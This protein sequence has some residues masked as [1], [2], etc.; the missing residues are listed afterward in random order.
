MLHYLM[1]K[2][3]EQTGLKYL[4][5]HAQFNYKGVDDHIEYRGSGK[6]WRRILDAHPEYTLKTEVLGLFNEED[7]AVMGRYYSELWECCRKQ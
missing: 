1:V 5:K 4:C 6:L 2:E 7:I 3:I